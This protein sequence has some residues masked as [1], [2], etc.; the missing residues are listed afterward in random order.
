MAAV[1]PGT[2]AAIP[3][4]AELSLERHEIRF[5]RG[6]STHDRATVPSWTSQEQ[7]MSR[8]GTAKDSHS[9]ND[10]LVGMFQPLIGSAP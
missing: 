7:H 1:S 9:F 5:T 4:R 6:V 3:S 8:P 2:A 10:L